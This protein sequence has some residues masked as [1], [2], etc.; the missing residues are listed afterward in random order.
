CPPL[1]R[2]QRRQRAVDGRPHRRLRS[3]RRDSRAVAAPRLSGWPP[4]AASGSDHRT[5][6]ALMATETTLP[7]WRTL[8]EAD[9]EIAQAIRDEL[10][11]QNTSLQLSA[12]GHLRNR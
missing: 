1:P 10:Q 2:A 8:A 3:R 9:A 12:S 6:T 7:L 4:P 5:G 11:R